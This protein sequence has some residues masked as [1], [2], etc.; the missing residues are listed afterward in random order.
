MRVRRRGR[1]LLDRRRTLYNVRMGGE[2]REG[3]KKGG[4]CGGGDY[5]FVF[6]EDTQRREMGWLI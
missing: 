3:G 4:C 2:F 5:G 1:A 6:A